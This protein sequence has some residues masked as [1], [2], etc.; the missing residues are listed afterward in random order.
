MC[1]TYPIY[2]CTGKNHSHY[3]IGPQYI[4]LQLEARVFKGTLKN[5]LIERK[6]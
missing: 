6:I 1:Q 4:L 2:A 3:F 5:N